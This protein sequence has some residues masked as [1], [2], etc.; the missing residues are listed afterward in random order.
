MISCRRQPTRKVSSSAKHHPPKAKTLRQKRGVFV[1]SL[2]LVAPIPAAAQVVGDVYASDASVKGGVRETSGGLEVSNGVA[3][4][5]GEHS[6]TL[7]LARGGQVR[8]CPGTNLT[9]NTS[10]QGQ[11]LMFAMSAGSL[12]ADY[13]IPFLADVVL[14]PDYR[15][16]I[17]GPADVSVS[18]SANKN[19]DACVRSRG[20]NSYVVVSEL[21]GD[22]FY[23]LKPDE[24]V[25]FHAGHVKD[26]DENSTMVCGC[27]APPPLQKAEAAPEQPAAAPAQ[28]AA[29][30]PAAPTPIVV[31]KTEPEPRPAS[32]AL[33][34]HPQEPVPT[35]QQRAAVAAAI[36]DEP[37]VAATAGAAAGLPQQPTGPVQV[38]V[39]APMVF[40]GSNTQPD[41]TATLARVHIERLPWPQTPAVA[42][43][44]P[45]KSSVRSE[46][47]QKRGFFRRILHALFG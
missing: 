44:P 5:A 26:P 24:Q 4:T 23:H 46:G 36:R 25:V 9:V 12:E 30:Q 33:Q 7:R 14:T 8:V 31:P 11:E 20:D 43:Q 28:V 39:D 47:E 18:I 13:S 16:L 34:A 19:G 15:I 35:P 1:L 45:R 3:I 42:P 27:P 29:A 6:A 40:K 21:M 22:D 38:Q 10:P 32:P 41:V 17:S 37:A 2:A